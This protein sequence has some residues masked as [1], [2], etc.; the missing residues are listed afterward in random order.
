[1]DRWKDY[2]VR[3]MDMIRVLRSEGK[4][5]KKVVVTLHG[6]FEDEV[7]Q[8]MKDARMAQLK[9]LE[10]LNGGVTFAVGDVGYFSGPYPDLRTE[11]EKYVEGLNAIEG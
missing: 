1:M 3:E 9:E 7:G 5:L 10:R 4:C 8:D 2:M 6:R 11:M